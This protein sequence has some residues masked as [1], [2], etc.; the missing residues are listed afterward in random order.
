MTELNWAAL[1]ARLT[2]DAEDMRDDLELP[3]TV[4]ARLDDA[5]S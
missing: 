1:L 5:F 4:I 2:I 3:W